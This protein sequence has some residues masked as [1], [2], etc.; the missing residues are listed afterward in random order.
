MS[1]GEFAIGEYFLMKS[2]GDTKPDS[3]SIN[4]VGAVEHMEWIPLEEI[5]HYNIKPSFL[6]NRIKE[7]IGSENVL[8]IVSDADRSV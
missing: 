7:I 6:K 3:H 8:H 1:I 2:R 5:E 4:A